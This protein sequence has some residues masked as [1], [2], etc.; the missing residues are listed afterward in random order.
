LKKELFLK[1][2]KQMKGRNELVLNVKYIVVV[3]SLE[4][5]IQAEG[6]NSMPVSGSDKSMSKDG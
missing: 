5:P 4:M 1:N 3:P 2:I 6:E